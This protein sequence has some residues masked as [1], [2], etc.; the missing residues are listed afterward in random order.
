MAFSV[1]NCNEQAL[2]P[3]ELIRWLQEGC[4]EGCLNPAAHPHL[5]Q[6]NVRYGA[7]LTPETWF[8]LSYSRGSAKRS[9][10]LKQRSCFEMGAKSQPQGFSLKLSKTLQMFISW[11]CSPKFC[12]QVR[13]FCRPGECPAVLAALCHSRPCLQHLV[14]VLWHALHREA[15]RLTP[16]STALRIA[17]HC[18]TWQ[19]DAKKGPWVFLM[20]NLPALAMLLWAGLVT[21]IR[22]LSVEW[23]GELQPSLYY[24]GEWEQGCT[25]FHPSPSCISPWLLILAVPK[26]RQ[27]PCAPSPA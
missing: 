8:I 3:S 27:L 14:A 20:R 17:S 24:R 22:K 2:L 21:S 10:M 11:S 26:H 13:D 16:Q 9:V 19:G 6:T 7:P 23:Q 1:E 5:S 12:T 25:V 15:W 4:S 18:C